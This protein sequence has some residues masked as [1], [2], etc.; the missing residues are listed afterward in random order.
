MAKEIKIGI[1][2]VL[3]LALIIWGYIFVKGENLFANNDNYFAY[4]SNVK[5]LTIAAPIQVNGLNV[6]TV[7]SIELDPDNVNRIKVGF[8]ISSDIRIP[9]N[10]VAILKSEN[11]LGGRI[12]DLKFEKMCDGTNCAK[13]G[14]ELKGETY[15][16]INSIMNVSEAQEFGDALTGSINN[17]IKNLGSE[18]SDA[19]LD[20]SIRN[21]AQI[22]EN[23]AALTDKMNSLLGTTRN[24]I[25]NT[26]NNVNKITTALAEN[27]EQIS[28]MIQNLNKM[29]T[30][31]VEADLGK[32]VS[33]AEETMTSA[34]SIISS[35]DSSIKTLDETLNGFSTVASKLNDGEGSLGQLLNDKKLYKNLE[36]T[37][38]HMALLLQDMRLNPRRYVN[39]SLIARKDKKYTA[40]EE[41]PGL[42]QEDPDKGN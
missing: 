11:A 16:L 19:A 29:S 23:L 20:K 4:Y 33:S 32:T 10:T 34:N 2:S 26:M 21:M 3:T 37:S 15:G 5:D 14:Q 22:T 40:P 9:S 6:G 25:D 38:R 42:N 8:T 36:E 7:K 31:L 1:L 41:D 28:E 17:T 30:Q 12:I 24:D 39:V 27:N 18:E 13:D 35:L